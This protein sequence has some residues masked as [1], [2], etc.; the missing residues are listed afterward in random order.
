MLSHRR[1]IN[2][3]RALA[4][5]IVLIPRMLVFILLMLKFLISKW[6]DAFGEKD[7]VFEIQ[8]VDL[9]GA[10]VRVRPVSDGDRA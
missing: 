9:F 4:P 10:L 2:T 5:I 6:G 3:V 7:G 1:E 8:V